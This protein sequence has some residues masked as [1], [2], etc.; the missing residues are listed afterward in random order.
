MIETL[1]SAWYSL[2]EG[3]QYTVYTLIKVVIILVPLFVVVAYYTLA[4]RKIIG[5]MQIRKGPNRVG[6]KGLL[7]PFALV[8]FEVIE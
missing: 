7:Q 4:E 1:T 8:R 6:F 5:Y 2:P 3:L